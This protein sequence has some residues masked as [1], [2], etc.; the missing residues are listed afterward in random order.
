MLFA[1]K[2]EEKQA[3]KGSTRDFAHKKETKMPEG[4]TVGAP[5][6]VKPLCLSSFGTYL[7]CQVNP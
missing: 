4:A 1:A 3:D 7:G 5:S 2:G 6:F